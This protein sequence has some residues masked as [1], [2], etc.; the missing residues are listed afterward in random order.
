MLTR[1]ALA[2]LKPRKKG[3]PKADAHGLCIVVQPNSRKIWRH[4]YRFAG[5]LERSRSATGRKARLRKHDGCEWPRQTCFALVAIRPPSA[6]PQWSPTAASYGR[7]R[8]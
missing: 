8:N 3:F 1:T 2:A 5:K 6:K 7:F 4:R